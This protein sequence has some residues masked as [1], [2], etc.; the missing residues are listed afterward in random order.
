M[1]IILL[2][3]TMK[4]YLLTVFLIF[5]CG[6]IPAQQDNLENVIIKGQGVCDPHIVIYNDTAYLFASHDFGKGQPIYRMD[7]WL[8]FSSPDLVNWT[9]RFV[10]KPENTFI[11][12]W[13]ECYATDAVS[14][15]GKYYMYFSQQQK[16][17]GV[18]VSNNPWGPYIDVLNKPLL[19]ADL[20]DTADY[21]PAV[22][23][24]DD[25]T[26]YLL[27]G[28]TVNGKNYYIAKLNEDM[29]SLAEKPRK[30]V[31][32][33]GWKND[34]VD[35]HKRNG[36]YYLN[37]HG[38]VYA[39]S[40]N[41]YGPYKYRGKYTNVWSDHGNFFTWNNQTYHTWGLREDWNDPFFRCSKIT[42]VHYRNNG[43]IVADSIIANANFGV[44]QYDARWKRIEAEWYFKASD[45]L[46][47]CE[48]DKGFEIR[49]IHNGS[50]L[51]YPKIHNLGKKA[52]LNFNVSSQSQHGGKIEIRLGSLTGK[53]L[54][55][56]NI[57]YTGG[58]NKYITV[59]SVLEGLPN[60]C[61]DLYFL[62]KG[63][64]EEFMRLDWFN[65]DKATN[66]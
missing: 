66:K 13:K 15:N 62:F 54:G 16:Q 18:A 17:T 22:F 48:N 20:T 19:P 36:I 46:V 50:Y 32:E 21:D 14:R 25:N 58:W 24:D 38:A 65:T 59:S 39:T 30:I 31:I 1:V 6:K 44:G 43:D 52:T 47:K 41:I 53:I 40:D 27:W 3:G 56:C 60:S 51:V 57:P 7:D 8:I 5:L 42:Y 29:M 49:N 63:N 2:V 12:P 10:L 26:P 9:K 4:I 45:G 61:V 64:N 35:I 55:Y 28:Y 34:A 37:S 23:V 33:N 11:G